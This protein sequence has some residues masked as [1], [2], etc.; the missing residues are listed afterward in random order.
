LGAPASAAL[1]HGSTCPPEVI[2]DHNADYNIVEGS[3][4]GASGTKVD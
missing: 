1:F 4:T 3:S 2:V